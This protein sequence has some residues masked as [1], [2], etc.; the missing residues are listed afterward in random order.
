[1]V[2][3]SVPHVNNMCTTR[4]SDPNEGIYFFMSF[5]QASIHT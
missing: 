3:S 4:S 1:M 2:G 5:F